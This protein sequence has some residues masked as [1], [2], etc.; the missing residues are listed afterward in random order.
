MAGW[1]CFSVVG[2]NGEGIPAMRSECAYCERTAVRFWGSAAVCQEH[3]EEQ[4]TLEPK[5][6]QCNRCDAEQPADVLWRRDK[7]CGVCQEAMQS[8]TS[9]YR[10]RGQPHG[11]VN[12]S[13]ALDDALKLCGLFE[14]E[15]DARSAMVGQLLRESVSASQ[16]RLIREWAE[17]TT[18]K[19]KRPGAIV[20]VLRDPDRREEVLEDIEAYAKLGVGKKLQPGETD[21]LQPTQEPEWTEDDWQRRVVGR[22]EG[23]RRPLPEVAVE[24]GIELDRAQELLDSGLAARAE[25]MKP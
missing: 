25:R 18:T 10:G 19:S 17:R 13:T 21:R 22:V 3:A 15:R 7:P 6:H 5:A 9:A 16:V 20:N 14:G 12:E 11:T 1:L 24:L 23:D 2:Q 8:D 4:R